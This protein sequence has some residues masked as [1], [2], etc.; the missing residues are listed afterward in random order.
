MAYL[1]D[2]NVLSVESFDQILLPINYRNCATVIDSAYVAGLEPAV[3]RESLS[4]FVFILPIAFSY[5][6]TSNANLSFRGF[7]RGEIASFFVIDQLDLYTARYA[8]KRTGMPFAWIHDR[9]NPVCCQS[10]LRSTGQQHVSKN[11]R[12]QCMRKNGVT[13][14]IVSVKPNP[15]TR[16]ATT[17]EMNSWVCSAIGP[18][19]VNMNRSRPPRRLR[20]SQKA[21]S[22]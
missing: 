18:P 2:C 5:A 22:S 14:A 16:G 8:A 13:Y 20:A 11:V 3:A 4:R 19:P 6:S 7:A 9:S 10:R 17:N 1:F 15:F 21:A 12:A